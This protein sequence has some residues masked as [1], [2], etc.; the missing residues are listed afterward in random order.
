MFFHSILP[1]LEQPFKVSLKKIAGLG[2]RGRGVVESV[3]PRPWDGLTDELH[4]L[5]VYSK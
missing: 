2:G 3:P 5:K 1:R 4:I